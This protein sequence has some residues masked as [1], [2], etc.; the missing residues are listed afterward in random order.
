MSGFNVVYDKLTRRVI[1]TEENGY[2]M[3]PTHLD[4]AHYEEGSEPVLVET[5]DHGL[6]LRSNAVIVNDL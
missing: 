4:L 1:L 6:Y 3:M 5:D 2:W